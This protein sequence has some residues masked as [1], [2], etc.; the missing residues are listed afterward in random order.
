MLIKIF[1]LYKEGRPTSDLSKLT[2]GQTNGAHTRSW[3]GDLF[4]TNE[5]LYRLSYASRT[6]VISAPVLQPTLR[7][8]FEYVLQ[9]TQVAWSHS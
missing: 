3:T 2:T 1:F 4:I 9:A 8:A 6:L 7:S 5:V